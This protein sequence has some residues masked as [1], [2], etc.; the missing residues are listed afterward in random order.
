MNRKE[1]AVLSDLIKNSDFVPRK[2][3][4][5]ILSTPEKMNRWYE[6]LKDLNFD[7][8]VKAVNEYAMTNKFAP[9]IADIREYAGHYNGQAQIP[10]AMEAWSMV[11]KALR[12]SAYNADQ[13]F[14]KLPPLVQKAVGSPVN[15]QSWATDEN[16][17][18]PVLSSQF[19]KDYRVEAE[20]AKEILKLPENTQQQITA[21]RTE[22]AQIETEGDEAQKYLSEKD[23]TVYG[24]NKSDAPPTKPPIDFME[25]ALLK[26]EG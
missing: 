16:Y 23:K 1:F 10:T 8:A 26:M 17:N 12:N 21:K 7:V 24:A 6:L 19:M 11:S 25:R 9:T 3:G 14:A 15:L 2:E 4:D 18:E 13:E 5:E 20:R 22:T